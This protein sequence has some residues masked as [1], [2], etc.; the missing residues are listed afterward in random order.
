MKKKN[1]EN[2]HQKWKK[3]RCN[4]NNNTKNI[5]EK[6][7]RKWGVDSLLLYQ[8][9]CQV[10]KLH[11]QYSLRKPFKW[12][13]KWEEDWSY[14]S[15]HSPHWLR[16]NCGKNLSTKSSWNA[17]IFAVWRSTWWFLLATMTFD[18]KECMEYENEISVLS[19]DAQRILVLNL[20]AEK[21]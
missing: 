14:R 7:K 16:Y 9:K 12:W 17:Q 15:Q 10:M 8:E 3:M 1:N 19:K 6:M 20:T 11:C 18:S 5:Y 2:F 4:E 21:R 13:I